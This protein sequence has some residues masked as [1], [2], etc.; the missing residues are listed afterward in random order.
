MNKQFFI[1]ISFIF[2]TI[3]SVKAQLTA[4]QSNVTAS[5]LLNFGQQTGSLPIIL[6][7]E[8]NC[9]FMTEATFGL[10]VFP[11]LRQLLVV[12]KIWTRK[13]A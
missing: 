7:V 8:R 10:I 11:L 12:A 9:L 13:S 3:F 5:Y 2:I 1:T 6:K 4:Y